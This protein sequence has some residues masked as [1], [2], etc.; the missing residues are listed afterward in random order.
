MSTKGFEYSLVCSTFHQFSMKRVLGASWRRCWN[1][2][3][4]AAAHPG[5]IHRYREQSDVADSA[6]SLLPSTERRPS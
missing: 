3:A 2:W 4:G 6:T 5:K 1:A